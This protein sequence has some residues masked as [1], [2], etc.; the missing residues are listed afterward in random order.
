[1]KLS[2][3]LLSAIKPVSPDPIFNTRVDLVRAEDEDEEKGKETFP[4]IYP[5]IDQQRQAIEAYLVKKGKP[6]FN[7]NEQIKSAIN[8]NESNGRS[9]DFSVQ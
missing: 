5:S 3:L 9:Y 1:M 8:R 2:D 4:P 6:S 7:L